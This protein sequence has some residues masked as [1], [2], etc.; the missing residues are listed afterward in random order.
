MVEAERVAHLVR[1]GRLEVVAV[2]AGQEDLVVEDRGEDE[3]E[4]R[5]DH[6]QRR[7]ARLVR[8]RVRVRREP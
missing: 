1:D 3:Q 2:P 8:V 4:E 5:A 6:R 7:D